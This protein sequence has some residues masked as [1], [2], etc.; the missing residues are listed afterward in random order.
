MN[1]EATTE[2]VTTMQNT[3]IELVMD[4]YLWFDATGEDF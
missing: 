3:K 1:P 4:D 2:L